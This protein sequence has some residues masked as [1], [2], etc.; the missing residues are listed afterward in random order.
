MI[1][2]IIGLS[3]FLVKKKIY[4]LPKSEPFAV[5]LWKRRLDDFS[6]FLTKLKYLRQ[7]R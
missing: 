1:Y 7:A 3:L 4:F 5:S 6:D 2:F